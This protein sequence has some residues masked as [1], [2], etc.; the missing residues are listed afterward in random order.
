MV[1]L[2][3]YAGFPPCPLSPTSILTLSLSHTYAELGCGGATQRRFLGGNQVLTSIP[4]SAILTAK[5]AV[6]SPLFRVM[7]SVWRVDDR[8][9][10]RVSLYVGWAVPWQPWHPRSDMHAMSAAGTSS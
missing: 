6:T 7:A 9:E 3:D 1:R 5:A 8:P 2:I 4:Y 10:P